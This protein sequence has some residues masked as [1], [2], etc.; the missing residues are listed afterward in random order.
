MTVLGGLVGGGGAGGTHPKDITGST[1]GTDITL[2]GWVE[3]GR[4]RGL[5]ADIEGEVK[6]EVD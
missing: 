5:V 4:E 3:E 1:G 2:E 6:R